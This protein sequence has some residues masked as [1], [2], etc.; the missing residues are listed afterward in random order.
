MRL[1]LGII[2]FVIEELSI[3][4]SPLPPLRF[5]KLRAYYLMDLVVSLLE[6]PNFILIEDDGEEGFDNG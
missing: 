5:V 2:I 3:Y 1:L 6:L 4:D